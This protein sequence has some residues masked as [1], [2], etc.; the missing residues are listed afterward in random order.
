VNVRTLA[1]LFMLG[2]LTAA[3]GSVDG[4]ATDTGETTTTALLGT[5]S[6]TEAVTTSTTR[7]DPTST[8]GALGPATGYGRGQPSDET[9]STMPDQDTTTTTP[10]TTPSTEQTTTT[11]TSE[12]EHDDEVTIEI[13]GFSFGAPLAIAAGT[14]VTVINRDSVPHTWTAD[15]GAFDSGRIAPGGSFSITLS[16]TGEFTFYC[17]IHPSMT[18]SITVTG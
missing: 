1:I 14:T 9:T 18:G 8:T 11:T 13:E 3:C 12:T 16:Q 15:D 4:A 10:G 17:Q 5:T 7:S 6:P 2:V